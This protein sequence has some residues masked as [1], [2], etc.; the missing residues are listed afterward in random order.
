VNLLAFSL[1]EPRHGAAIDALYLCHHTCTAGRFDCDDDDSNG[2]ESSAQCAGE[3]GEGE[4]E[5]EA[6]EGEG[7]GEADEGEGEDNQSDRDE[8]PD[9]RRVRYEVAR[10]CGAADA[11]PHGLL[12]LLGCVAGR[13]RRR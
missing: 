12:L 3:E 8:R 5:G 6:G 7:E 9:R 2:C 1:F 11:T 4:G 13:R 10:S